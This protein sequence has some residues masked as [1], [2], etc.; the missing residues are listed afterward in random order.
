MLDS[1][2][3][4]S[5]SGNFVIEKHYGETVARSVCDPFLNE[6]DAVRKAVTITK[7]GAAGGGGAG[8]AGGSGGGNG[9]TK[10]GGGA[11]NNGQSPGGNSGNAP[12]GYQQLGGAGAGGGPSANEFALGTAA[13]SGGDPAS[14]IT[15]ADGRNRQF[16]TNVKLT[17]KKQKRLNRQEKK[18]ANRSDQIP[19]V[20]RATNPKTALIHIVRDRVIYLAVITVR[21][22]ELYL[23]FKILLG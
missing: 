15:S 11:V 12:G 17:P 21:R 18:M 14:D 8:K 1:L 20:M 7:A 4:L 16:N 19:S 9:N 22:E 5:S 3:L 10:L 2:F 23:N 6:L 13:G